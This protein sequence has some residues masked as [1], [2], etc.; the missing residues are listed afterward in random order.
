MHNAFFLSA[1]VDKVHYICALLFFI[2]AAIL[3]YLVTDNSLPARVYGWT[4][5]AV[6][7]DILMVT[8]IF[9]DN[10]FVLFHHTN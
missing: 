7:M 3:C 8:Y 2:F 6:N 10:S 5:H 9:K 1:M 4:F